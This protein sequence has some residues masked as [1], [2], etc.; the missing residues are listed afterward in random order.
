MFAR[1]NGK[2]T[3]AKFIYFT[4]GLFTL[5]NRQWNLLELKKITT[6]QTDPLQAETIQRCFNR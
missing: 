1:R 5:Q 6:K 3:H 4:H 2:E